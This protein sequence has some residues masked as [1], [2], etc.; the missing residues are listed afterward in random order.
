M[1]GPVEVMRYGKTS[2]EHRSGA[3]ARHLKN[4][5]IRREWNKQYMVLSKAGG[6]TEQPYPRI[7]RQ[8]DG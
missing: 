3:W 4:Q 2:R 8:D 1:G 7:G 6:R 5:D